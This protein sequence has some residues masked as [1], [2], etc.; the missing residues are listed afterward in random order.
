V[1]MITE[2]FSRAVDQLLGRASGP[3]H[4]RLLIQPIVAAILAIR[5]GRRDAREGKP[6]FLW[7][8]LMVRAERRE[9]FRS[10]RNDIGKMFI[11]AIGVDAI[12][13]LIELRAFYIVQAV[14]VAFV[15]AV[16]PYALL[17]GV[18]MRV[19][20]FFRRQSQKGKPR[21]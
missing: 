12:Y 11:V 4:L 5:A 15:L 10:A 17:R 3:L 13:Q 16:I 9:L 14:I 7:T 21:H 6:P 1:N 19:V 2:I 20:R 18:V 8:L